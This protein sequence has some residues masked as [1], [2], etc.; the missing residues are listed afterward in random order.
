M[1]VQIMSEFLANMDTTLKED[2]SIKKMHL[3]S[4]GT[5]S[6]GTEKPDGNTSQCVA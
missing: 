5:A 4:D 2:E 6:S 3:G 1:V